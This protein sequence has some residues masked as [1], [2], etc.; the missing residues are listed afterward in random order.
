MGGGTIGVGTM[1]IGSL[2]R[3]VCNDEVE[4][5]GIVIRESPL[6]TLLIDPFESDPKKRYSFGA[7]SLDAEPLSDEDIEE[8]FFLRC[9]DPDEEIALFYSAVEVARATANYLNQNQK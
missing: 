4:R 2:L 6:Q 7:V 3:Q 1:K 5:V 9:W 8:M